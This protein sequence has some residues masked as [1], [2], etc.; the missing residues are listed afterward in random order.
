MKNG[1]LLGVLLFASSVFSQVLSENFEG[2]G[3]ALPVGWASVS[4]TP[5]SGDF[6]TGDAVAANAGG[7]W[8]VPVSSDFAMVIDDVCNCDLS[9]AYLV[10][11][12]M[13]FTGLTGVVLNYDFV[14]DITY[15]PSLPHQVEVST[16]LGASWTSI[17][18][19]TVDNGNLNWQS[20]TI[21]LGAMTDGASSVMVRWFYN[22]G[23]NWATGLAIDNVVIN[24]SPSN[25]AQ[26]DA[27]VLNR[28]AL[29]GSSNTLSAQV[30]NVGSN[31]INSLEMD[32][33][34]GSPHP[35][36]MVLSIAPGVTV[37]VFHPDAVT[38]AT[39]VELNIN[40]TITQVN[41]GADGDPSNNTGSALHNTLSQ[42]TVKAVV[43][44]EGTGT[45][46]GWCPRGE[47]A[48]S[49]MYTTYPNDFIGIA[50]HNGDPMTLTEY[51]TGGGISGFP[52]CNVDRALLGESVSQTAFEQFYSDR[53]TLGVP[54]N[55]EAIVSGVGST[56]NI[57]VS[58]TFYTPVSAGDFRLAVVVS[59]N[60]VTGTTAAYSQANY[61]S[62][63]AQGPMGG[64]ESLTD[65][66][67][68]VDM[69]YD[70]VGRALLGGYDGQVGSV[71]GTIVDGTVANFMFNYTVPG[72]SN[73]NNMHAIALLIDNSTGEIVNATDVSINEIFSSVETIDAINLRVYPNPASDNVNVSFEGEG[74]FT[75]TLTDMRGR[76]VSTNKYDN[77]SGIQTIAV[78]VSNLETGNYIISVATEGAS[79]NQKVFVK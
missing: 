71:P 15:G 46:C 10:S 39:A 8:P 66:V 19:Y 77:L 31:V 59:E 36:T 40:V 38:Y 9:A 47:V 72:T 3:G 76:I 22:D 60:G 11:P 57:D 70:H 58:A 44:E 53:I 64:Y 34:D 25:D 48:M 45:W 16:N 78:S 14:D 55:I 13:D 42:Q 51:D 62:G 1:L 33:N 4:T 35:Q 61:Y 79:Y 49:Y 32:W 41:G 50:V 2:L 52:G 21:S 5:G 54:A 12:V 28:W 56:V 7:F 17:Y 23:G 20:N 24:V 26:L 6:N 43:I 73:R 65:P 68:A 27:V 18:T 75:I 74:D 69:V 30:T 29:V 37:T 67:P 63:G